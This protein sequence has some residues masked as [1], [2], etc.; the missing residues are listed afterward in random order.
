MHSMN[1]DF[2][3]PLETKLDAEEKNLTVV[4]HFIRELL[5]YE[6]VLIH[7]LTFQD[8]HKVYRQENGKRESVSISPELRLSP[9]CL[10]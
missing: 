6:I 5:M 1:T 2:I 10:Y 3:V 4:P 9:C 7:S 8:M